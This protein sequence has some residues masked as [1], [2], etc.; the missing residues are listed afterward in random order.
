MHFGLNSIVQNPGLMLFT[1]MG[2]VPALSGP[3]GC[4]SRSSEVMGQEA[5]SL[6]YGLAT[7]YPVDISLLLL[8]AINTS[9]WLLV[10]LDNL[11][12]CASRTFDLHDL[13]VYPCV[14]LH[15]VICVYIHAACLQPTNHPHD[16]Q[17]FPCP[18]VTKFWVSA[19]DVTPLV[20]TGFRLFCTNWYDTDCSL[21]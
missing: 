16:Y 5:R 7:R 11:Q 10:C 2:P 4:V 6:E 9:R 19:R 13:G 3:P 15:E 8:R 1:E 17:L 12:A 21:W 14:I 18:S 20:C